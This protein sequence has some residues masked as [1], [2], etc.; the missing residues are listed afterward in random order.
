MRSNYGKQQRAYEPADRLN[1]FETVEFI[2]PFRQYKC[3]LKQILR[4][5]KIFLW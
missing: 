1:K 4:D 5:S 3:K 2:L